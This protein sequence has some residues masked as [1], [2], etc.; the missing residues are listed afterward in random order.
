MT[1]YFVNTSKM[2]ESTK[3]A[4]KIREKKKATNKLIINNCINQ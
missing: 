2:L 1:K 3:G 4:L